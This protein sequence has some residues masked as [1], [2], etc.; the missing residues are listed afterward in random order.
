MTAAD[1]RI[2]VLTWNVHSCIGTDRR[3]DPER[4]QAILRTLDPDIAA[5]Q[6]VDSRRDLRDGFDLLGN[7]LSGHSAEV[8]TVRTA[9]RDYGH[10]LLSRWTIG[11]WA[12]HDI[13]FRR[14]EPRSLIEARIDTDAGP[15]SVLAA[16]LGLN[17]GERRE[18]VQSIAA[19]ADA[20]R[21]PTVILG[22]F[23]EPTGNG[24]A[25]RTLDR[26][27]RSVGRQATFPS[28]WPL[29][30]LDRIWFEAGLDLLDAGVHR[31]ARGASDHLPLWADLALQDGGGSGD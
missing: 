16:H 23:N 17:H 21:L 14:R 6:E 30:P 5:L 22:D 3:F 1:R 4:V 19:L 13:S 9:D 27:F 28:Y 8:R 12:H 7:T 26:L 31:D 11:S 20:D 25:G 15:V 24:A 29:L 2:R 10:M 18:Q